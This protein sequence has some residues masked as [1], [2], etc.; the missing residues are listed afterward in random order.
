MRA[1]EG[2]GYAPLQP[3]HHMSTS[4]A[5]RPPPKWKTALLVWVAIYPSITLLVL[6][7]GPQLAQLPLVI[8]TLVMTAILV[9]L[10]VFVLLPLLHKAF[11]GWL[12]K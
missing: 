1:D 2:T 9:P 5:H 8:R 7:F 12:R 3:V 10:L 4:P 6:F 11:G